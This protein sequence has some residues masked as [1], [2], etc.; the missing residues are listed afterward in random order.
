[1][2]PATSASSTRT[3]AATTTSAGAYPKKKSN[4][5]PIIGGIVGGLVGLAFIIAFA[6]T[7][8]YYIRRRRQRAHTAPSTYATGY[9]NSPQTGIPF[10][11]DPSP[12]SHVPSMASKK[13]YVSYY[14]SFPMFISLTKMAPSRTPLIRRPFLP[15]R[16]LQIV[17]IP[18]NRRY[19]CLVTQDIM[20]VMQCPC[21]ERLL[22]HSDSKK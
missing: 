18:P 10:Q 8:I 15:R 21:F 19:L 22:L 1:M 7:M 5:G 9:L 12:I 2:T 6:V 14:L 11:Y 17:F 3:S 4:I 13:P 20:G 16:S